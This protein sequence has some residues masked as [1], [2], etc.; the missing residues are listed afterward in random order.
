MLLAGLE[1]DVVPVAVLEVGHVAVVL[2]EPGDDFLV[3]RV[4]EGFERRLV[5]RP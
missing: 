3:Q 1:A 4:L 2:L 5:Q